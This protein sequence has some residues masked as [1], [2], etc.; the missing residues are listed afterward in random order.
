MFLPVQE[1]P[2]WYSGFGGVPILDAILQDFDN[3]GGRAQNLLVFLI[4]VLNMVGMALLV[5]YT[6][7]GMSSLPCSL[8]M[9]NEEEENLF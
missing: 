2:K 6:A 1:S 3:G 4:N 5:I 9:G 7:Y 8:I